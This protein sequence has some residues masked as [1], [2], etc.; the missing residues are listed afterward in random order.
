MIDEQ[1][2]VRR[3]QLGDREAFRPIVERY[4]DVLMGTVYLMTHDRA[5]SED[6]VKRRSCGPGKA[7]G[8]SASA[9]P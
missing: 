9:S 6:L 2:A 1:D 3:C 4:G 7:P 8:P 5:V